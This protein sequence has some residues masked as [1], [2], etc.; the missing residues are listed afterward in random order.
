[1]KKIYEWIAEHKI[2]TA[3]I[4]AVIFALP[5]VIVHVLYKWYLGIDWLIPEWEPGDI[6]TYV[7]GFEAFIGT[8]FLGI[9]SYE[10]NRKADEAN[11]RLTEENNYFQKIMSQKLVP[12]V[13]LT[14][15]RSTSSKIAIDAVN[16]P[17]VRTFLHLTQ[18]SSGV[19]Q[20]P[21]QIIHINVDVENG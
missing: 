7:A 10:Q 14:D 15:L 19:P 5:L 6:L 20:A 9:I 3:I 13:Q 11:K 8:V 1:M 16:F 2:W 18:Y 17:S 21:I 12:V 4:C